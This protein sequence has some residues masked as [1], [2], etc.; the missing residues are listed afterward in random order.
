MVNENCDSQNIISCSIMSEDFIDSLAKLNINKEENNGVRDENE[1][2]RLKINPDVKVEHK[3]KIRAEKE[4]EIFNAELTWNNIRQWKGF[5]PS[6]I[7]LERDN[8]RALIVPN[9]GKTANVKIPEEKLN[10]MTEEYENMVEKSGEKVQEMAKKYGFVSGKWIIYVK[11]GK[12]ADRAWMKVLKL[13]VNGKFDDHVREANMDIFDDYTPFSGGQTKICIVTEDFTKAM[14]VVELI[15]SVIDKKM[16]KKIFYKP[17]IYS[18][19][20]IFSGNKIRPSM[21]FA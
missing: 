17:D 13:M 21:Y 11:W 15:R 14:N 5:T 16:A 4:L 20:Q 9:K 3:K 8:I 18:H 12:H 19:L 1:R 2:Q 6:L 10:A 7:L